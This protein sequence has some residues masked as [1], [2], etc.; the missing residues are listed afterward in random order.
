[1]TATT[2]AL[3]P[4]IIPVHDRV[5][6]RVRLIVPGLYGE[7]SLQRR[8]EESLPRQSGIRAACASTVT[9]KV[10]IEYGPGLQLQWLI[11]LVA[12]CLKDIG[13]TCIATRAAQRKANPGHA[14][15]STVVS[16][17][18]PRGERTGKPAALPRGERAPRV[19]KAWHTLSSENA[20]TGLASS[21]HSGL[22]QDAAKE[23]LA[24]F[25]P[26]ELP[27][28]T[29]RSA[30]A[31]LL[32]QFA[33]LPVALLGASAAV[34]VMTGG[35]VDALVILGVVGINAVVGYVTERQ[36]ERTIASMAH[37]EAGAAAVL[38]DGDEQR[39]PA[40]ALVP[41]DI[42][43]L[44][45]G[46]HVAA[47]ARLLSAHRL[48]VDES[49]LTGE[50]YP[51]AKDAVNL[52]PAHTPL[53]ERSNFVYMGATVTGG[54][55]RAVVTATG[56]AT[57]IGRVH[58]MVSETQSPEP[59]MQRQLNR[60]GT[61]L[62]LLSGAVCGAVFL[63]GL[64]RGYGP[65]E[66]LKSAISLAVAAVPEGLPSVATTTLAMGI[67]DMRRK[68][69]S[70]R[71]LDAVET[72]GAMQILCL[73]KTG[74]LTVNRMSLAAIRGADTS[75][76]CGDGEF[77]IDGSPFAPCGSEAVR[78]L[79]EVGSLCS[80]T[81]IDGGDLEPVLRGSPTE[82]ALVRGA[83]DA[84]IDV[85]VLRQDHPRTRLEFRAE[86]QSYMRS[87]HARPGGGK[88]LAIKGNPTDVLALCDRYRD[89]IG[90]HPLDEERRQAILREN[91]HMAGDGLRI[92]GVAH[93]LVPDDRNH[94]AEQPVW[95]GLVGM[96]DPVRSGLDDLMRTFHQAG[97][98]TVM[99]TGDQSGTAFAIGKRLN[100]ANGSELRVLES[101]HLQEVEPEL[102]A[103]LVGDVHVFS[104]VSP[105]DKLRIVQAL[106]R[107]GRTVAM[108]GDGI[109][110]APALKAA[111]MGVAMGHGGT[112]VARSVADV[113]IEDD[114]LHT[115]ISA[116]RQGR[117]IYDNIRKAIRFLLSTNFSEIEVMLAG[118]AL[119]I[120]HPLNPMQ[121]LWI[122]L[123]TDIF[124]ALAL[125]LEPTG[126]DVMSRPPRSPQ[127]PIITREALVHTALESLVLTGGTL[128]AF[129]Y[130]LGRYGPGLRTGTLAF[131]TLTTAQLL[132]A[133]SCRFDRDSLFGRERRP[134]NRRL[135][136]A[137]GVSLALQGLTL[138]VPSLRRLLG[139]TA[140]GAVDLGV[141]G[142]GAGLPLLVNE[143]IKTA[144]YR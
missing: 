75:V 84:G 53:A 128:G 138:V 86:G 105:G 36:A 50:S 122:N 126:T 51:V 142:V 8:I 73:D 111:D 13:S 92:L 88:L 56:S 91:D 67:Q 61:Q 46:I 130:G 112:N 29:G 93:A 114:N 30:L 9:G 77:R 110:D 71:R 136:F 80:E 83:F 22:T 7:P 117:S 79:L 100:L 38:R 101:S 64:L 132:H 25:G 134:R 6:G 113:I 108:T 1:M 58:T 24:C 55:G 52:C 104:R 102:L 45:P 48:S 119:G 37:L 115:M 99:I 5:P 60:L 125:S 21:R 35:V 4:D 65:L 82:N 54:S 49:A 133:F 129:L 41:G 18:T 118:T 139:T 143:S 103:G 109:N 68:Q 144:R 78:Q 14:S 17:P 42:L 107:G 120:G 31:V 16:L 63:I 28:P 95:L 34:C 135:E 32:E 12:D 123:V 39:V 70:I 15:R 96:A 74:T 59:P 72:L 85:R 20:L 57:E 81:E 98:A 89:E 137:V 87:F 11:G 127:E 47:D 27:Q 124:P 76:Q 19:Q 3:S 69:V 116:V 40:R 90:T 2:P 106:R 97:I 140:L 131:T 62:G 94:T 33:S 26:N 23:R 121:L 66:M 10:L 43:L 141:V 44:A